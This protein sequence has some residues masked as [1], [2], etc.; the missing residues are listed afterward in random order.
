MPN[1]SPPHYRY[2]QFFVLFMLCSLIFIMAR[3][4]GPGITNFQDNLY[5]KD[6]LIGK[7][8]LLRINIGDR[9]FPIA[10]LGKDGWMEYTG[11]GNIDDFQN[12]KKFTNIRKVV[13]RLTPFNQYLK[14]QGITLLIVVAPNKASIY[15]D[16]L[17]EQINSSP[18]HSR[19]DSLISYLEDNQLPVMVDL[20]P[21]LWT[22]RQDQDVYYKT[23][24]HWNGY[25]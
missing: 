1:I 17:A 2:N 7:V 5:K 25:G 18:T 8:N 9:V 10:L 21:A 14:S 23:N 15:P 3:S 20:R 6:F 16:K 12:L 22:A 19:L 24:T 13:K 4:I 11:D